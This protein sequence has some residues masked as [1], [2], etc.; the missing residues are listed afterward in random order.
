MIFLH[1][2]PRTKRQSGYATHRT[3]GSARAAATADS[4]PARPTSCTRE[5][6]RR[7]RVGSRF[8]NE[9]RAVNRI[10]HPSLVQVSDYGQLPDGMAYIVMEFL[11]GETLGQRMKR[12]NGKLPT[13]DVI[14]FGRQICTGLAAAHEKEIVHRALW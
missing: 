3:T 6:N 14:R 12:I 1:S 10:D 8:F 7:R 5:K 11:K 9:A 4:H 2:L 13:T